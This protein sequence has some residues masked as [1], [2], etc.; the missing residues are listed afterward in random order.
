MMRHSRACR[1]LALLRSADWVRKCLLLGV[2]RTYR[3]HH[4]TDAFDPKQ[5]CLLDHLVGAREQRRRHS[6]AILLFAMKINVPE[7]IDAEYE[8]KGDDDLLEQRGRNVASEIAASVPANQ[9]PG[10]HRDRSRPRGR[11]TCNER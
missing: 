9:R 1:Q 5:T 6:E 8:S 4:E 3:G 2:D 10:H 7:V 11:S